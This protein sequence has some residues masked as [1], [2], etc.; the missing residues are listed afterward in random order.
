M[1]AYLWNAERAGEKLRA[2]RMQSQMT[3]YDVANFLGCSKSIINYYENGTKT[4]TPLVMAALASLYQ[5]SLED[6]FFD[7]LE[8]EDVEFEKDED[9]D[10]DYEDEEETT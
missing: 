2:V 7:L 5:V 10:D 4:P 1:K 3:S 9:G 8:K 6:L